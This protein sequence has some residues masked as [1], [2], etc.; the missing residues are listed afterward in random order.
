LDTS[1]GYDHGIDP[2]NWRSLVVDGMTYNSILSVGSEVS[3]ML[4]SQNDLLAQIQ[5]KNNL[6]PFLA[7]RCFQRENLLKFQRK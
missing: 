2:E 6:N 1:L 4:G 3:P 5:S 7:A